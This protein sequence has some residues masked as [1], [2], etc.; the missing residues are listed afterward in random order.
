MKNK[1]LQEYLKSISN[2]LEQ[3]LPFDTLED[4]KRYV[5]RYRAKID[6]PKWYGYEEVD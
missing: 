4:T 6:D 3:L 5:N 2:K 1:E